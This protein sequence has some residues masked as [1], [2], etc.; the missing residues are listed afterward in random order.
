[1][2]CSFRRRAQKQTIYL[3]PYNSQMP[4]TP[5]G[6]VRKELIVHLSSRS[7]TVALDFHICFNTNVHALLSCFI[8]WVFLHII[9]IDKDSLSPI[10]NGLL[11]VELGKSRTLEGMGHVQGHIELR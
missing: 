7:S 1:M 3:E 9:F 5:S 2:E 6:E 8:Y 10:C 11:I 4:E